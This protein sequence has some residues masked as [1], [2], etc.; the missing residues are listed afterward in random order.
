MVFPCQCL[1]SISYLLYFFQLS[2][3]VSTYV[4]SAELLVSSNALGSLYLIHLSV[5]SIPS[6]FSCSTFTILSIFYI[7]TSHRVKWCITCGK[8]YLVASFVQMSI[9]FSSVHPA[10][11]HKALSTKALTGERFLFKKCQQFL[12]K[13]ADERVE[14]HVTLFVLEGK[15]G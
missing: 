11:T 10:I 2:C 5:V 15:S 3:R 9:S 13:A 4:Q 8:G 1:L 12:R 7:P 14:E 6:L